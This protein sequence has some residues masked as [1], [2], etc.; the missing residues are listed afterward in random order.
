MESSF[1]YNEKINTS[2][3]LRLLTATVTF[4]FGI[5]PISFEIYE[6]IKVLEQQ[7]I[8]NTFKFYERQFKDEDLKQSKKKINDFKVATD[9]ITTPKEL[10][11]IFSKE[12]KNKD[13]LIEEHFPRVKDF[14]IGLITCI[15]YEN[16]HEPTAKAL[17]EKEIKE[18]TATFAPLICSER[19][20]WKNPNFGKELTKFSRNK[21]LCQ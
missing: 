8:E 14:Y 12:E 20:K 19:E 3:L 5:L 2:R 17:F 6:H 16:C 7:K 4:C 15:D 9:S 10:R 21:S 18:F 11:E 1:P 13:N